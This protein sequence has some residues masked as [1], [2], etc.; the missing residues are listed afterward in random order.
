MDN[1]I[2]GIILL[3]AVGLVFRNFIKIFKGKGGCGCSGGCGSSSRGMGEK[4]C[5]GGDCK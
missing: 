4:T 1:I 2:M 3:L 5:C